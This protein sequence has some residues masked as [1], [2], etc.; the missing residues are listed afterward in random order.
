M[1]KRFTARAYSSME[2]LCE[3]L[4]I[5]ILSSMGAILNTENRTIERIEHAYMDG[6]LG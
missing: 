3:T 5:L 2:S 4:I 1:S 6:N